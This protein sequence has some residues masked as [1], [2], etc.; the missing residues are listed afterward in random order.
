[1][2]IYIIRHGL[3]VWNKQKRTQGRVNNKLAKEGKEELEKIA[4]KLKNINFDY[5]FCSPLL[6]AVQSANIINFYHKYGI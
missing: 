5:I 6:R 4:Q 1:M 2:K 3:T